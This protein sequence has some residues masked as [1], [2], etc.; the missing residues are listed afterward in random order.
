MLEWTGERYL[1]FIDPSISG[2][3]IHYEHLHRY[4]FASQFVNDKK[5]LDLACGEGYGSFFLAKNARCV[6]GI[7]IYPETIQHA[8]KAYPKDNLEFKEGSILDIPVSGSKIFDVIVCFEALEHLDE[9]TKLMSE[10]MRLLKDDGLLIISTPNKKIYSDDPDY[11]NPFHK[12]ELY[13]SEFKNVLK[14]NFSRVHFFGQR[15]IM[16]SNIFS[17]SSKEFQICTEFV[18]K[19]E[20]KEFSFKSSDEKIPI[21]YVA[22]ATNVKSYNS[23]IAKSFLI[24]ASNTVISLFSTQVAIKDRQLL[25]MTNQVTNLIQTL[26][27]KDQELLETSI[28]VFNLNQIIENLTQ[29]LG[30]KDQELLETSIHVFNLNQIIENLTQTLGSKDQELLETSIHVFNLNQTLESRN[31]QLV[32][33]SN[34]LNEINQEIT[35]L[36]E[37]YHILKAENN[38]MKSSISNQLLTRFHM[39]LIEPVFPQNS[40]RREMYDLGR[41]GGRILVNDG[42]QAFHHSLKRQMHKNKKLNN[43][44][45]WIEK[46][47]PSR[48]DIGRFKGEL[49]D[50]SYHPKISI[51]MPVWN[52]NKKWLCLAIDSVVNQIYDNWELCIVDGGSTKRYIKRVLNEYVRKD[53]RIKVKFLTENKGIAGN[54]NE[55]LALATGDFVG[56][57]DHDDELVPSTLYEVVKTLN[58]Y[59][60]ICYIYS[61][62]DK[63]DEQNKR[64]H[65]FFKPDWS[66]DMFLSCNYICHF[67]VIRKTLVDSVGGFRG[68]YDGSQDYD[69]FLR[70]TEKTL[71]S[72]IV[73]IPKILYHW[74]MIK[75]SAAGVSNAKPYAFISARKALQ[76]AL[77]R[78]NIEGE[79]LDGMFP[80]SYRVR[81]KIKNDPKVSIIIPT[82]DKVKIL[83]R[84]INSVLEKTEY[85]NYEIVIV[86]NQSIERETLEYYDTLKSNCKIRFLKYES[87]FNFSAINNYAVLQIDSPYILFLNND[88][89]VI[90]TEWLTAMLE[91][92]QRNGIGAVGAKLLYPNNTIQHAGIV[93]GI[94]G[95]PSVG[96]HSHRFFSSKDPGYFGRTMH[97]SDVSGVTGACMLMKKEIFEKIG[98]FDEAL[99]V[100]FNDVDLCLKLRKSGLLIVYTPYAELYHHESMTRGYENTQEKR[101]RFS[102][103]VSLIREKWGDIIDKGDPYYNP[104]LT[105]DSEDFSIRLG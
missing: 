60:D 43:Y 26:G 34:H 85:S 19:K 47:E 25:E 97:S 105:R 4:A 8:S 98:G 80:S 67:S 95:N 15:T 83:Q 71:P 5:V 45:Q 40:R 55:A 14:N 78:R 88:T 49:Q 91:H 62:E 57:L 48:E 103:E 29:T 102:K 32:E 96:G 54:S 9:H 89:E 36:S 58:K 16:G 41:A 74:R 75:G 61:D 28:H 12:K 92:A 10:I 79:V 7:D 30:S 81:Y 87:S 35:R 72:N 64:M 42:F 17:L 23:P 84:C 51:I 31:Q 24:D 46:N 52:T 100:A 70:V 65:P 82:K 73:H 1:P 99:A 59:P 101:A 33:M 39:N 66:P 2:A 56:F 63:I 20:N 13:F 50:F 38:S 76:D 27:S 21:Y 68:G 77:V 104:N 3:E 94:V 6:L 69:L 86:D 22:L 93:I 18:I 53:S 37:Q 90:S 11:H 44:Q